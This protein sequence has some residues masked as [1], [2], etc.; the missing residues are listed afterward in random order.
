M[1]IEAIAGGKNKIHVID[2]EN[3]S[4]RNLLRCAPR[5][6]SVRSLGEPV[7]PPIPE[8]RRTLVRK[9]KENRRSPEG[10]LLFPIPHSFFR[11]ES[12]LKVTD[13]REAAKRRLPQ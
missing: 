13:L 12:E 4:R 10:L 9:A 11:N 8:E 1:P 6:A 3:A 2:Q 7:P 5:F